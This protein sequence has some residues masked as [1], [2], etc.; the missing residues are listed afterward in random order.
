MRVN[1]GQGH[2]RGHQDAGMLM[3]TMRWQNE[4]IGVADGQSGRSGRREDGLVDCVIYMIQLRPNERL[5]IA[6][7]ADWRSH[8]VTTRRVRVGVAEVV[9][10]P[11]VCGHCG[12]RK[13]TKRASGTRSERQVE[14]Q[15]RVGREW[16]F[17]LAQ[18]GVPEGLNLGRS[19]E[20]VGVAVARAD[21][22]ILLL[23]GQA[24]LSMYLFTLEDSD[25]TPSGNVLPES[26][27]PKIGHVVPLP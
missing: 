4:V 10:E 18:A 26:A 5:P 19:C 8:V 7:G 25:W 9:A 20:I 23:L 17:R 16:G 11:I 2:Q 13:R 24:I 1:D 12:L 27:E 6:E 3:T 15:R 21:G 22:G 14:R